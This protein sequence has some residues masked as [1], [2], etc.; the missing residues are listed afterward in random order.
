[1][2]PAAIEAMRP[3]IEREFGN[4]SSLHEDGRRAKSAIDEAREALAESLGC[5]FAEVLFTSSGTEA[6]NLAILGSALANMDGGRRRILMSAVEH[7][8]VLHTIPILNKLGFKVDLVPVDREG[9]V[10]LNALEDLL[11]DDVLLLSLMHANNELGT[12]QPISEAYAIAKRHG[13]MVHCDAVQTFLSEELTGMEADLL[14]LSAHKVNGPKGAGA[15]YIRAGIKLQPIH[16]GGGQ[17]REIRARTENVAAIAGFGAAVRAH[18]KDQSLMDDKKALRDAFLDVLSG[19]SAVITVADRHRTLGGHA[20]LRFPGFDAE[21]L[22]IALDQAGISA[23]S[24]A[25]C[26]SGSLEPS[27]VLTACGYSPTEAKEGLRFT[28]GWPLT[29]ESAKEAAHRLLDVV[30]RIEAT[31]ASRR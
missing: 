6:A 17:E 27:H 26:S 13:V 11:C 28:F 3:W 10:D 22:L 18:R 25:A 24:G 9:V 23:S 15:I 5:L 12:L 7:H 29:P 20:H 16:V 19:S 21:T 8:C 1:M 31:R 2:L 14:T 4:P 30:A